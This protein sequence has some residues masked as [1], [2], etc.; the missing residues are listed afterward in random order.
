MKVTRL[1]S[2]L[3]SLPYPAGA[4][5]AKIPYSRRPKAGRIYRQRRREME[6]FAAATADQQRQFVFQR[7]RTIACWA[8]E[9][10][11]FYR[12]HYDRQGFDPRS[13][14]SFDDLRQIPPVNKDMMQQWDLEQ[15]SV[16]RPGR[17]VVNT[18]GSSGHPL[19]F[20]IEPSCI[21]HEWA[22]MHRIWQEVGYRQDCLKL[23]F[24]GRNMGAAPVVYDAARHHYAVNIYRPN[25]EIV[26]ALERVVRRRKI[27]FLH[28][29]P[30]AIHEFAT[31]PEL[32]ASPV[33]QTLRQTVRAVLLGSEYPAPIYRDRIEQTFD[34]TSISWYGH[35]ERAILAWEADQ[36]YLYQPFQTYGFTEVVE[37]PGSDQP[38]L[39]GTSYYNFA[40]PL[41]RYDTADE[42][43]AVCQEG[44]LLRSFRIRGGRSGDYVVDRNGKKISLTAL[45]FGRHHHI[46]DAAKFVQIAQDQPGKATFIITPLQENLPA[47]N[48]AEMFDLGGMDLECDFMVV[49]SPVLTPGGKVALKVDR[50]K[51]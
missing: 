25:G 1:K 8:Y 23:C 37:V 20:Y 11:A 38:H 18:G 19:G 43:E 14:D 47:G 26:D 22:H 34:C 16:D 9:Q 48:L 7:V 6:D 30:S 10:T 32:Q 12:H 42:V 27:E 49:D 17:Y 35:T 5:L 51:A 44:G 39:L 50:P 41:V 2:L 45:V 28:G 31:C 21:G 24:G 3:E 40:S 36:R 33:M 46:F 29:Y 15:R 4:L 13:L